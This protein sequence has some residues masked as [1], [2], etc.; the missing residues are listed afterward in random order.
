MKKCPYC[1]EEIQDEAIYCRYCHRDLVEQPPLP[2]RQPAGVKAEVKPAK[3]LRSPLVIALGWAFVGATATWIARSRGIGLAEFGFTGYANDLILGTLSS[4]FLWGLIGSG[5]IWL[6][7]VVVR[8]VPGVK[9]FSEESGCFSALIFTSFLVFF[10]IG[11]FNTNPGA[12]EQMTAMRRTLI[13]EQGKVNP[14]V[15]ATSQI[16]TP[17]KTPVQGSWQLRGRMDQLVS[18]GILQS[19][20]GKYYQLQDFNEYL[21]QNGWS[22]WKWKDIEPKNFIIRAETSWESAVNNPDLAASGC[23]FNF[24]GQEDG[25]LYSIYLGMDGVAR[26]ARWGPE[27]VEANWQNFYK[28]MAVPVDSAELLLAVI[29]GRMVFIVDGAVV[30][31]VTDYTIPD[32]PLGLAVHSGTDESFGIR[33]KMKNVE[34]V[35]LPD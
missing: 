14:P 8:Q 27:E 9:A 16:R 10:I 28:E 13:A 4:F 32:G 18:L 21:A 17:T 15:A 33:C 29:D 35:E 30:L 12:G 23:G 31:D 6:W 22:R 3:K 26:L 7:R 5:F 2:D 20:E 25:S 24:H 19:Q 34:L 11:F 1:A